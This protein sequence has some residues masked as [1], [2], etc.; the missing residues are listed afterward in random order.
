MDTFGCTVYAFDPS[1]NFSSKRE[2]NIIFEKLGV[3]SEKNKTK[4]TDTLGNILKK[5]NYEKT[6][7]S[8]LKMKVTNWLDYRIGHPM[9]LQSMF[10][11]LH[12]KYILKEQKQLLNFWKQFNACILKEMTDWFHMSQ[13]V[14]GII[15]IKVKSFTI[16]SK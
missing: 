10:S 12:L 4:L 16:F 9:V 1:V 13:V 3:G 6:K 15:S 14:A 2:R 5:H 7:I 8:Y 11:K